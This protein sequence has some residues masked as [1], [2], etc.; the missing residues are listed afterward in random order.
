MTPRRAPKRLRDA[1]SACDE[2]L[3]FTAGRSLDYY[4]NDRALRLVVER[5]F[6]IIGEALNKAS[7]DDP[8]L[9]EI[10]PD[11]REIIGMRNQLIH[12]Y[13]D[14]QDEVVW[15]TVNVDIPKL[16]DRLAQILGERGWR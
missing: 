4:R 9:V 11:M 5:L 12:G 10:I 14:I 6:E 16:R 2:L 1:H 13:W 15:D 3:Q 7:D 8:S